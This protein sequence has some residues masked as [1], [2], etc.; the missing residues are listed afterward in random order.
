[1]NQAFVGQFS[2]SLGQASVLHQTGIDFTSRTIRSLHRT[3]PIQ[4]LESL[5]QAAHGAMEEVKG[6]KEHLELHD[7]ATP[8]RC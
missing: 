2:P 3:E 1:M 8:Y 5:Q 4:T 6:Y 7:M